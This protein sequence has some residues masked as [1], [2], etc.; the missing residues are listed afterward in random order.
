MAIKNSIQPTTRVLTFEWYV[1]DDWY[2]ERYRVVLLKEDSNIDFETLGEAK[3]YRSKLAKY[4]NGKYK[5]IL[6]KERPTVKKMKI[7][8]YGDFPTYKY[9]GAGPSY[10][11][12]NIHVTVEQLEKLIS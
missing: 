7:G 12:K 1:S 3:K 9:L 5:I 10:S 6:G 8:N 11:C 4:I 2:G